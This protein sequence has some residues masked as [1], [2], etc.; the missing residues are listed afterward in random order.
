MT[1]T[2][3]RGCDSAVDE[4]SGQGGASA[5]VASTALST[6]V[7]ESSVGLAERSAS[8][9]MPQPQSSTSPESA[10]GLPG[11]PLPIPAASAETSHPDRAVPEP[12]SD[13]SSP[14]HGHGQVAP[15]VDMGTTELSGQGLPGQVDEEVEIADAPAAEPRGGHDASASKPEANETSSSSSLPPATSAPQRIEEL[16]EQSVRNS[17]DDQAGTAPL[18]ADSDEQPPPSKE[19]PAKAGSSKDGDVTFSS[20]PHTSPPPPAEVKAVDDPI[21]APGASTGT[22]TFASQPEVET[23]SSLQ[24][25]EQSTGPSADNQAGTDSERSAAPVSGSDVRSVKQP[26]EASSSK[27]GVDATLPPADTS[28]SAS[29]EGQ[30]AST[31]DTLA[32]SS[33][34]PPPQPSS[35]A[36]PAPSVAQEWRLKSVVFPPI[37][38]P[39]LP[40][41]SV[42]IIMQDENGP[43]SLIALCGSSLYLP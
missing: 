28:H 2:G 24:P 23:S 15:Q 39:S 30:L 29:Q 40:Q 18:V 5:D 6:E 4:A 33:P 27:D 42:L 36:P 25:G 31:L 38:T 10:A 7:A 43:C 20:P 12:A 22:T 21:I 13:D 1:E 16:D 41:R 32:I 9:Q 11:E 14:T 35:D 3:L 19:Q 8:G 26:A 17:A 37:P 34:T